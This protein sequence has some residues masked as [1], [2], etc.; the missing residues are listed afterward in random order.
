MRD[1]GPI[2][3]AVAGLGDDDRALACGVLAHRRVAPICTGGGVTAQL[4]GELGAPRAADLDAVLDEPAVE[5]VWLGA[6]PWRTQDAR[7]VAA[8]GR[9]LLL[10]G[11]PA[12]SLGEL[13]ELEE[14]AREHKVPVAVVHRRASPPLA[15]AAAY[16]AEGRLGLPRSVLVHLLETAPA[17]GDRQLFE[18]VDAI[19]AIVG[20]D[21]LTAYA[22]GDVADGR[23]RVT[24]V[25]LERDVPA[26][27]VTGRAPGD[28]AV[29]AGLRRI[30]L[31]GS[32]GMLAFEEDRPRLEV[33]GAP[34]R[35]GD[36]GAVAARARALVGE[37]T[38]IL[39]DGR[40]PVC[41]LAQARPALAALCAARTAAREQAVTA[42]TGAEPR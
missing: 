19:R 25:E 28:D 7:R 27:V 26:T 34:S 24:I 30:V 38:G 31:V 8:S 37:L 40:A 2:G 41:G 14:I 32:Q 6:G 15:R 12:A 20:L 36:G 29:A 1:N 16:V 21:P 17:D 3:L 35:A 10:S 13:D 11:P 33:R 22:A 9:A 23:T 39:R 5:A 4:A 42:I 18:A